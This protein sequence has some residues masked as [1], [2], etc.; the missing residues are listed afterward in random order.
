MQLLLSTSNDL[1]TNQFLR[2]FFCTWLQRSAPISN[3]VFSIFFC[4]STSQKHLSFSLFP[5]CFSVSTITEPKPLTSSSGGRNL[6]SS[7]LTGFPKNFQTK[8]ADET[9][10]S[11]LLSLE[12]FL[13]R[14]VEL[15]TP[16]SQEVAP[17]LK[18][19]MR[20]RSVQNFAT[21]FAVALQTLDEAGKE[22]FRHFV[23]T[24]RAVPAYTACHVDVTQ[25][26]F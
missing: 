8:K 1:D 23:G 16:S 3:S 26:F 17:E 9:F 22:Q 25:R 24:A 10:K 20:S 6:N 4:Y 19:K 7:S 13:K 5:Q 12:C 21:I 14:V 11:S 2:V 18:K 15:E